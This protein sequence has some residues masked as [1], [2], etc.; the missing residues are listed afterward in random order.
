MSDSSAKRMQPP[1]K[2]VPPLILE[3]ARF[4]ARAWNVDIADLLSGSK[5]RA[6]SNARRQLILALRARGHSQTQIGRWLGLDHSSVHYYEHG[7][8]S[9]KQPV[10][11]FEIPCPDLSG[12]WAI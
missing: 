5:I 10:N 7:R 9:Q 11:P 4:K 12:E 6:V 8:R 2:T 1:P 3:L